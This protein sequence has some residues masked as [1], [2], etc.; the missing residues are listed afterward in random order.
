MS[1]QELQTQLD[2]IRRE[3]AA[4]DALLQ[5]RETFL[6]RYGVIP[7]GIGAGFAAAVLYSMGVFKLF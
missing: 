4:V 3:G 5:R 7:F 2:A 1:R 6:T